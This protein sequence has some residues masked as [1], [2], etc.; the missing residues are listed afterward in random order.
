MAYLQGI[1]TI[2]TVNSVL[3]HPVMIAVFWEEELL[4]AMKNSS[5]QQRLF[6][7]AEK[8]S[9]PDTWYTDNA[10]IQVATLFSSA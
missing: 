9:K 4:K 5:H 10:P 1:C 7:L 3:L 6:S 2:G 8:W